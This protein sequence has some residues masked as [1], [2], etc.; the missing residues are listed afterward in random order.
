[1]FPGQFDPNVESSKSGQKPKILKTID[2]TSS[3]TA[4]LTIQTVFS[5]IEFFTPSNIRVQLGELTRFNEK[6]MFKHFSRYI[7]QI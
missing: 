3:P 1:M 2:C 4:L 6:Y 7:E 5:G